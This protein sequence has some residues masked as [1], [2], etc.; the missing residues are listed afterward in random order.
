MCI[1]DSIEEAFEKITTLMYRPPEMCDLYQQHPINEKVDIWMLG[2]ILFV[3]C[4]YKHPFAEASKLSIV[5]ASFQIPEKSSY[6]EKMHDLIRLLLT[7]DPVLRPDIFQI[8][9]LLECYDDLT[10]IEL[11]AQAQEI[12]DHQQK[13]NTTLERPSKARGGDIPGEEA[14][15]RDRVDGGAKKAIINAPNTKGYNANANRPTQ[16]DAPTFNNGSINKAQAA[17]NSDSHSWDDFNW[18]QPATAPGKQAPGGMNNIWS[19]PSFDQPKQ[20]EAP[21]GEGKGIWAWGAG[22]MNAPPGGNTHQTEVESKAS[23][24]LIDLDNDHS[25]QEQVITKLSDI[26]F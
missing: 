22:N 9:S 15:P 18:E 8:I 12:K 1:R 24:Y 25:K 17:P 16:Q 26:K 7:P 20:A 19:M 14:R 21:S 3:V 2:C 13:V 11:N 23:D 5:N 6:S 10:H 4:F